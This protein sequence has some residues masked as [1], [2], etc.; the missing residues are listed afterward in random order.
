M[1]TTLYE[2]RPSAGIGVVEVQKLEVFFAILFWLAR[3]SA[4][5]GVVEVQKLEVFLRF[6]FGLCGRGAKSQGFLRFLRCSRDP[7]RN[8]RGRGTKKPSFFCN[9][10][11]ARMTLCGDL[12]GRG[13]LCC[14]N[15]SSGVVSW[16]ARLL[17][18]LAG[19][20]FDSSLVRGRAPQAA[21]SNLHTATCA[22]QL[23]QTSLRRAP[24]QSN[25][26]KP[27][28]AEQLAHTA[29]CKATCAEQLAHVPGVG[30]TSLAM[31]CFRANRGLVS[32]NTR[33]CLFPASVTHR[34]M[35]WLDPPTKQVHT[36]SGGGPCGSLPAWPC[37][38]ASCLNSQGT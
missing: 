15:L 37:R 38:I 3:P 24:C 7:L 36:C 11:G 9:F 18:G 27:T 31:L 6:C 17:P 28:C 8:R 1:P 10:C 26:R 29:T 5:I 14:S 19:R 16:L 20:G 35:R 21:R 13:G 32:S 12:R 33:P 25:L 2:N 30:P 4:G 23:A 22:E 34:A